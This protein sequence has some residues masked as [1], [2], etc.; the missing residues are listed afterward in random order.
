MDAILFTTNHVAIKS[1]SK[2]HDSAHVFVIIVSTLHKCRRLSMRCPLNAMNVVG[3]FVGIIK[4]ELFW[5]PE[6]RDKM[7]RHD[8]LLHGGRWHSSHVKLLDAA[9]LAAEAEKTSQKEMQDMVVVNDKLN[10][11]YWKRSIN[12][13]EEQVRVCA[14]RLQIRRLATVL[15]SG[16][17]SRVPQA[18]ALL[19]MF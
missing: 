2:L 18:I 10:F 17:N 1:D 7:G 6:C 19:E 16:Q 12:I 15:V 8:A 4:A 9:N 5:C 13:L 11:N 3:I 14:R